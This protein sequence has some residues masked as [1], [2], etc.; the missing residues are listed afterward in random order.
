MWML[1]LAFALMTLGVLSVD[2]WAL[3]GERRELT[4]LADA[5]AL[6]GVSAVDEAAWRSS[7]ILVLVGDEAVARAW[8][9]A[10]LGLAGRAYVTVGAS[11]Q[12]AAAIRG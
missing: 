1:G 5:A 7:Q 11:S 12:A 3:I 9:T 4:A 8:E 10:L 6:A 2:L